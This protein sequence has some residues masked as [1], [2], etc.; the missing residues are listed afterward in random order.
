M[1]SR[2]IALAI[3]ATLGGGAVI[4]LLVG[5][6]IGVGRLNTT[7]SDTNARLV[8]TDQRV[9]RIGE[10]VDPVARTV[11]TELRRIRPA[12]SALRRDVDAV[13]TDS[14]PGVETNTRDLAGAV[15]PLAEDIDAADLP[16]LTSTVERLAQPLSSCSA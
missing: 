4:A 12:V 8:T 7:L 3:A 16:A 13:A 6:L 9:D 14:L 11:P 15:I 10:D 5:L 1:S 2:A